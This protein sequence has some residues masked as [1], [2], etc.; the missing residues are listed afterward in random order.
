MP[1]SIMNEIF[2]VAV[3]ST[4]INSSHLYLLVNNVG[5]GDWKVVPLDSSS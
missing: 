1:S 2:S 4:Q 5:A 3:Y